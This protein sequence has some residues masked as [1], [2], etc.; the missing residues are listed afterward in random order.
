MCFPLLL[1]RMGMQRTF[2]FY[3][4]TGEIFALIAQVSHIQQEC[5][6]IEEDE[7]EKKQDF[8][9]NQVTSSMNYKTDDVFTRLICFGLDIQIEHHLFPNVPH[10]SLRKI[11]HIVR[12]Y[13]H[14]HEIPYRE[15]SSL[16]HSMYLYIVYIWKLANYD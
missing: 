16:F 2:L 13:C 1:Y 7:K 8:L 12:R 11:Q 15:Q 10:S 3:F 9:Y 5:V 4:C 6:R 14:E